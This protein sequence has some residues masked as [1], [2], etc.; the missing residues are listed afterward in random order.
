MQAKQRVHRPNVAHFVCVRQMRAIPRQK[1]IALVDRCERKMRCVTGRIARHHVSLD[2][3]F[4]S[5]NSGFRDRQH[6]HFFHQTKFLRLSQMIAARQFFNH[7]RAGDET[8]ILA[9]IVP[10]IPRPF[11]ASNGFRIRSLVEIEA[12]NRC[13]NV[14]RFHSFE[15]SRRCL[16]GSRRAVSALRRRIPSAVP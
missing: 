15:I 9:V 6:F 10:P 11:A 14:N 16:R 3:N 8:I 4:H 12:R 1:I 13:F 5:L 7:R 2:I